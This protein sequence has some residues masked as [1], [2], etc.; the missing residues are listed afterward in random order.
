MSKFTIKQIVG[1]AIGVALFF[2]L[3]RFLS[4]PVFANTYLTLQYAVLGFFA[5]IFG[6]ICGLLIG[7]VGHAL[8]DLSWGWGIWWSWVIASAAVGLLSGFV[9]KTGKIEDGKF[10][11]SDIVRFIAGSFIAHAVAWGVVAPLLDI[12]IYG[13]PPNK[14]FTQ[15]LIAGAG[16][17]VLTAI[18]GTLLLIGYAK[19]RVSA[20]S[21]EAEEEADS[22]E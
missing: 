13:E 18:V 21:L 12:L 11:N 15:G 16:N 4:V 5:V 10:A 22:D 7:L 9:I 8:A 2:L 20:G 6:P 14:V 3:A 17:F 19:T 1:T